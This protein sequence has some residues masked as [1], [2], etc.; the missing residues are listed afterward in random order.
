M[1]Q[2]CSRIAFALA[3]LLVV[4]AG[5]TSGTAAA[6]TPTGVAAGVAAGV[7]QHNP[8]LDRRVLNIAHQGGEIE[9]PSDTM[10]AFKTATAKG[11]NVLEMDVHAT[12][13]GEIVVLHDNTVDRTT[14]G[15]GRVDAL[16]LDQIRALDAAHW[17]V[18]GC[19]TCTG[20]PD[21]DYTYRG[22]ATGQRPI[23]PELGQFQPSDFRIPTLREVLRTF[24]DKLLNIEIK[25]T[26]PDTTPYEATLAALLDEFGRDT[27]TIVASFNDSA[28]DRFKQHNSTVSTSP[29]IGDVVAFWLATRGFLPGIPLPGH[30]ALQ[31]PTEYLGMQIVSASFVRKAH[32]HGLAVHVWT[33][34][35][36][37]QMEAMVDAG[38]DGIMTNR[39]TL[40][41][42]VLREKGVK[43]PG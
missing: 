10:F 36:R 15:T 39:P 40:L 31:V 32:N 37:A 26:S 12:A 23:P 38:V 14:G 9:A 6:G 1:N 22:F 16:T 41:E 17:F 25:A 18:P 24:P 4:P 33:I 2:V 35:D 19:G 28:I 7:Q 13:D 34:D 29:G 5:L 3:T 27:D 43:Y 42:Q 30:H 20:R 21:A 8:W 11:A